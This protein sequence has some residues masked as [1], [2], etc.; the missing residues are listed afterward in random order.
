M[1]GAA[2]LSAAFTGVDGVFVLIPPNF[3][4]TPG[5]PEVRSI[6]TALT[7]ALLAAR[8]PKVVYLSTI[9][10]Q[11]TQPN[12]LTQLGLVEQALGG[13]PMPV[14][15]LR[16]AWFMENSSPA[17]EVKPSPVKG[18]FL[19]RFLRQAP[20]PIFCSGGARLALGEVGHPLTPG[21]PRREMNSFR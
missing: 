11:A 13:L 10:A 4:P 1:N 19:Y 16:A 5:L 2:G 8:P 15:A 18:D 21:A 7:T 17:D 12:L 3:D 9:G 6:I 20:L 14:C